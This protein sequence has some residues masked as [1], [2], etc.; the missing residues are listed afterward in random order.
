MRSSPLVAT[1]S[2]DLE[3]DMSVLR[4]IGVFG[5]NLCIRYKKSGEY[6][7]KMDDLPPIAFENNE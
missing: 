2:S 5:T 3:N 6:K 1:H 7:D 4:G